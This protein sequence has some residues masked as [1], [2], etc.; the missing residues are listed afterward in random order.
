MLDFNHAGDDI[1]GD[2]DEWVTVARRPRGLKGKS[3]GNEGRGAAMTQVS[4][5]RDK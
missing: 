4:L 3:A 1:S 2:N 5:R